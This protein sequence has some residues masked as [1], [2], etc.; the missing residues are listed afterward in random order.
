MPSANP[1]RRIADVPLADFPCPQKYR[2][3]FG[4]T[5]VTL[6][7]TH[8]GDFVLADRHRSTKRVQVDLIT[9]RELVDG[10]FLPGSVLP[11]QAAA[12]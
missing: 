3:D 12:A 1:P 9:L 2:M 11:D 6:F 4:Y 8:K 10:N 7:V 5:C